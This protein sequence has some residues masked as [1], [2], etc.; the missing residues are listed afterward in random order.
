MNVLME[1]GFSL[2]HALNNHLVKPVFSL[3][4]VSYVR[5]HKKRVLSSAT[6][7]PQICGV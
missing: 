1:L 3:G 4:V 2:L 7:H 5:S 6:T